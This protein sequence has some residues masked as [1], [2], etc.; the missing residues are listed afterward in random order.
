MDYFENYTANVM[1]FQKFDFLPTLF[2]FCCLFRKTVLRFI[3]FLIAM[4]SF[5][6]NHDLIAWQTK[7]LLPEISKLPA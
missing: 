5:F 4:K 7:N 3:Q 1:N 2:T 6:Y